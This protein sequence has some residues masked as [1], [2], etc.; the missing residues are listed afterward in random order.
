MEAI[1]EDRAL[2]VKAD[3]LRA[4]IIADLHLGFEHALYET[5]GIAYPAQDASMLKRISSLVGKHTIEDI[6]II[7]DVKHSITVDS[8]PNWQSVP[9]FM[10]A[11]TDLCR[12][13][14][15]P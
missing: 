7:G 13:H 4:L 15:I 6:H 2:V 10:S 9:D 11:L 12:I 3:D 14:V 1:F 8:R 5:K